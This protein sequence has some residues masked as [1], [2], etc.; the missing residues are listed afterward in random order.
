MLILQHQKYK[1][2]NKITVETNSERKSENE[3]FEGKNIT[4]E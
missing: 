1:M 4:P 3:N 2:L